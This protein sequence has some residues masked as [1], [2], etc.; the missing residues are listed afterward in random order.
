MELV[1]WSFV[2]FGVSILHVR[3]RQSWTTFNSLQEQQVCSLDHAAFLALF[4]YLLTH[5]KAALIRT[6]YPLIMVFFRESLAW[7]HDVEGTRHT[8]LLLSLSSCMIRHFTNIIRPFHQDAETP[9][10]VIPLPCV[11]GICVT[12]R[13]FSLLCCKGFMKA[14]NEVRKANLPQ[15]MLFYS[16]MYLNFHS[17]KQKD[18]SFCIRMFCRI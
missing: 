9:P 11:I 2:F 4:I 15:L 6:A 1:S 8:V 16:V 5:F 3:S 7:S 12:R 17:G 18:L 10:Q 13:L 14:N